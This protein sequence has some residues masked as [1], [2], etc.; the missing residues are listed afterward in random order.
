MSADSMCSRISRFHG[1]TP[2]VS[3]FGQGMC[4]NRAM[5]AL[6]IFARTSWGSSAKW[7]S[8]MSTTGLSAVASAATTSAN[9]AL[10]ST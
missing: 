9:F 6:G 4:Q 1:H 2:K 8:W 7:K 5:V 10:T 3:A